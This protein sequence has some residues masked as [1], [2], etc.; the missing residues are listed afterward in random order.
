MRII[1]FCRAL[2]V[3][4]LSVLLSGA[5]IPVDELRLYAESFQETR[6]AGHILL[7]KIQPII[8]AVPLPSTA[9]G[10]S[11]EASECSVD[12]HGAP[13]CFAPHLVLAEARASDPPSIAVRRTA[14]DLI[15]AYNGILID[16]S[17]GRE[18][19]E[20][21]SRFDEV[22]QFANTILTLTGVAGGGLPALLP[23]VLASLRRVTDRARDTRTTALT[24]QEILENRDTVK[25]LL[26]HLQQDVPKLYEIYRLKRLDDRREALTAK[27]EALAESVSNDLRQFHASLRIYFVLL[28]RSGDALDTLALAAS[29][30]AAAKPQNLT[31]ALGEA[32]NLRREAGAFWEAIRKVT[33]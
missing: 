9:D 10:G 16:L 21:R 2:L 7:D 33:R 30:P 12:R 19:R 13:S 3:A 14:L 11:T 15:A 23:P 29:K 25:A 18:P 5:S 26:L 6:A 17:S 22:G 4:S 28:G 8:A 20:M 31:W 1:S 32:L 24:R 27:N